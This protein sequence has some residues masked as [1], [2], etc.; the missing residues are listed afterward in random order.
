MKRMLSL[1]LAPVLVLTL[2][3]PLAFAAP[4]SVLPSETEVIESSDANAPRYALYRKSYTQ[5]IENNTYADFVFLMSDKNGATYFE[6]LVSISFRNTKPYGSHWEVSNYSYTISANRF[7]LY[8]TLRGMDGDTPISSY[9]LDTGYIIFP[10]MVTSYG[11]SAQSETGVLLTPVS[12]SAR[13]VPGLYQDDSGIPVL[14][15][16]SVRA[17]YLGHETE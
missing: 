8:L 2:C 15:P 7:D 5:Y 12:V 10:N 13:Y 6:E 14:E 16:V 3:C 9:E 11:L 17:F 1:I 4:V